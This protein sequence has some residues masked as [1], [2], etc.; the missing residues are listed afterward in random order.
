MSEPRPTEVKAKLVAGIERRRGDLIG[1]CAQLVRIPSEN[2]PGNTT[3][4]AD[5]ISGWLR[6]RGIRATVHEPRKG[7]PNLVA[8]I[9]RG[10]PNL[11][12]SGHLDEFPAGPGWSF[13]PFSGRVRDGKVMGRGAGDMKAGLAVSLFAA[14]LVKDA[15]LRLRG[16]LT[17]AFAS[18]EE[19]GGAWGTQWLLRHV[20]AVRGDACLIG[21]SSGTWSI[22]IGEKG[23]LWLRV[24]AEGR[25]GH[26]AYALGD[27][28][29]RKVL[30]LV[31]AAGKLHG[32][33]GRLRPEVAD[34]VRAQRRAAERHWGP[35]TGRLADQVTVNV[36]AI[37]GGGQVN[38]IP[39]RGEAA[40]DF[41]LPP[42]TSTASVIA[43]M[44]RAARARELRGT[45]VEVLNRCESY[46]TSP[47]ARLVQLVRDNARTACGIDAIPVVRLGYTDGR[48]F[49]R[50]GIPTVVY[51]PSVHGMGGPDEFIDAEELVEVAKVH[52]AVVADYLGAEA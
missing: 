43:A 20:N 26:A 50:E 24:A 46:V 39:A 32:A 3:A 1:L 22:G 48:F 52:A 27:S 13:P 19:T 41:R 21:E 36:G 23:V 51:G 38:L 30:A 10:A 12:L 5:F 33:R 40:I 45:T 8:Q 9:G 35:G 4:I 18:D 34:V 6:A 37:T 49:R 25:S 16:T 11:V 29:V 28:A 2:P 31:T 15:G 42:G 14:G 47:R 17:L 7:M 44:R